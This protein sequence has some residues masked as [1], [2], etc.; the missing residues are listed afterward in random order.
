MNAAYKRLVI[1]ARG[2]DWPGPAMEE[3]SY[4]E[5]VRLNGGRP[6]SPGRY[7]REKQI[8]VDC[9]VCGKEHFVTAVASHAPVCPTTGS[10]FEPYVPQRLLDLRP[11]P[12]R[13]FEELGWPPA[14]V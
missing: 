7:A 11:P 14:A 12:P 9:S 4:D 1:E 6:L 8:P 5:A 10:F 13:T 2:A 3:I